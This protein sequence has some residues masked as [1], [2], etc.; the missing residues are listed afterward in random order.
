MNIYTTYELWNG[1]HLEIWDIYNGTVIG[2]RMRSIELRYFQWPWVTPNYPIFD[3]YIIIGFWIWPAAWLTGA[4]GWVGGYKLSRRKAAWRLVFCIAFHLCL[5]GEDT[6][7]KFGRQV[8][9]YGWQIIPVKVV[10]KL[11]EPFKFWWAPT[12]SGTAE[13]IV[14]KFCKQ[15]GCVKSQHTHE[16]WP[17]KKGDQ[18]H[19]THF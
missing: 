4:D 9:A 2:T 10:V 13:A 7:F 19:V 1:Y 16:K 12:I 8:L 15:V 17:L 5:V 3:L 11:R 18:G 6:Q 14:V